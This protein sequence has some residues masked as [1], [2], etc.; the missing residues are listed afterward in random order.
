MPLERD[1][2]EFAYGGQLLL[3]GVWPGH[4]LYTMKFPGTHTAYAV[5]MALFGQNCAG[6]H[7]GF[8]LVNGATIVLLFLLTR[9]LIGN[10][11]GCVAAAAYAL[12]SLSADVLGSSAHATHLVVFCALTGL[13]LLRQAAEIGRVRL[14]LAA[15]F[16]LGC[17]VLMKHVGVF[18][19]ALGAIWL[20]WLGCT[21]QLAPKVPFGR[22]TALLLAGAALPLLGLALILWKTGTLEK[23]WFWSV[24]YALAY[25]K[26]YSS[27]FLV[28]SAFMQRMP[29]VLLIPFYTALAG[30]VILWLRSATRSVA[31]FATALFFCSLVAVFPGVHFRPHYY[32]ALLPALGL[33][34]GALVQHAGEWLGRSR[35]KWFA[36]VPLL[37]ATALFI[38]GVSRERN[39]FFRLSP[40]EA[41][42]SLYGFQPFP[43]AAALG[44][45][46]RSNTPPAARIAVLGSEP[47]IYFH[48]RRRSATGYVYTYP[49]TEPQPFA[50]QM[51][52]EMRREIEIAQPQFIVQARGPT[53]WLH[54]PGAR[55]HIDELCAAVTTTNYQLIAACEVFANEG[56][57]V[58]HWPPAALPA[59]TNAACELLLFERVAPEP[60]LAR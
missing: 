36:A 56:R 58:W 52:E 18:F 43:E 26:H 25:A 53:S 17:S 38:G 34:T 8:L 6:V 19:V 50:A 7:L 44:E 33:L 13:W 16:C 54:R 9:G 3:Q 28:W 27:S 22:A 10:V 55:K 30:L 42:R 51:R 23:S 41:C 39:F 11:A 46:I 15:G 4:S 59:P 20:V 1:E 60:S 2:G 21:R 49:L 24:T 40:V 57:V 37:A 32:V 29:A 48:A 12:T 45:F 35:L 5:W 31:P 14:Y 47:E